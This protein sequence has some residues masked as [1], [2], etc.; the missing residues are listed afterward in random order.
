MILSL[1]INNIVMYLDV[2]RNYLHYLDIVRKTSVQN[3][4]Q[5]L[6]TFGFLF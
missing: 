5:C 1:F 2:C 4:K 3:E 6:M